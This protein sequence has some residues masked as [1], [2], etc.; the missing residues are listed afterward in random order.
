[1]EKYLN[2][3]MKQFA[4]AKGIKNIDVSSTSFIE[5]F[6]YWVKQNR[7]M[8]EAYLSFID[9]IDV[10]PSVIDETTV[11]IGK[12]E[13]DSIA[14]NTP[15]SMI[16]PYTI[17]IPDEKI[18]VPG[19]FMVYNGNPYVIHNNKMIVFDDTLTSRFITQNPYSNEEI[20][21][22]EQLHNVGNNITLGFF[23]DIHDFDKITKIK[24]LKE[25]KSKLSNSE[26]VENYETS[27]DLYFYVLSSDR[28]IKSLTKTR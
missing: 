8:S 7:I 20:K 2:N 22:W 23:G 9:S 17:D 3:L 1:M 16:T 4:Q 5:E 12:C 25:L 15:M 14:L 6:M 21:N 27:D 26:F 28:K 19:M 18:L 24:L 13:F 11:E 10:H